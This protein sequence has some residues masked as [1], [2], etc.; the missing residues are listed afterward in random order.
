VFG[1]GIIPSGDIGLLKE[2]GLA[3]IFTPGTPLADVVSWVN[4]NISEH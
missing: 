2:A 4:E 1:G 3:E